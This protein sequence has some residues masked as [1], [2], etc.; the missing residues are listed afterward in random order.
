MCKK[1]RASEAG[2]RNSAIAG[3]GGGGLH[4]HGQVWA[5]DAVVVDGRVC[6]GGFFD[7]P[8]LVER[9]RALRLAVGLGCCRLIVPSLRLRP[10]LARPMVSIP[11]PADLPEARASSRAFRPLCVGGQPGIMV[12][13][14]AP[15]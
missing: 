6:P 15:P 4:G 14:E 8:I 7:F 10:A 9:S 2:D 13:I 5:V 1:G 11:A 3:V 12:G